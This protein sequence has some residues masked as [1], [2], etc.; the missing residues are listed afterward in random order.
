MVVAGGN[1]GIAGENYS[2]S[3]LLPP[4]LADKDVRCVWLP[5]ELAVFTETESFGLC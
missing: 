4:T 5:N 2:G 1:N 3:A